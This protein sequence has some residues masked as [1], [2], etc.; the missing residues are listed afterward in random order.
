MR[1]NETATKTHTMEEASG[2]ALQGVHP[3]LARIAV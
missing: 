2:H 3:Q 1:S